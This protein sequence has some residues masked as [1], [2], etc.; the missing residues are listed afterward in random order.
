MSEAERAAWAAFEAGIIADAQAAGL[1]DAPPHWQVQDEA[2]LRAIVQS[3]VESSK[4]T[5]ISNGDGTYS[6]IWTPQG[7]EGD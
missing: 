6:H 2:A 1:M 7:G 4:H 3:L 5:V